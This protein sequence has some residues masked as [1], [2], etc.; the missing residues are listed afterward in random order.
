MRSIEIGPINIKCM[1]HTSLGR[2]LGPT[3]R[4]CTNSRAYI[5]TYRSLQPD[6]VCLFSEAAEVIKPAIKNAL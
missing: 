5:N 2:R 4:K 1:G 3:L 6:P